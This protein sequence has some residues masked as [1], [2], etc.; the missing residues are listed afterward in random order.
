ML[1][2]TYGKVA[3]MEFKHCDVECASH[4]NMPMLILV[5]GR[6]RGDG[7]MAPNCGL[8]K[9]FYEK[10]VLLGHMACFIQESNTVLSTRSVLWA[11]PE[12]KF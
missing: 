7:G 9:F 11:P 8:G 12:L 6:S 4:D 2:E 5:N 10:M 3:E 1:Q